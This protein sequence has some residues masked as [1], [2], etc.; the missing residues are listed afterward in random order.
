[1]SAHECV[2][3]LSVPIGVAIIRLTGTKPRSTRYHP[4]KLMGVCDVYAP[5][6]SVSASCTVPPGRYAIIPST[7]Q[8][9]TTPMDFVLQV[10]I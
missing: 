4:K 5:D 7:A 2:A 8:S 3:G 6:R 9:L 1:M 10:A